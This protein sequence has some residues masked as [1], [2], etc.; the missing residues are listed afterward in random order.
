MQFLEKFRE[1]ALRNRLLECDAVIVG[2]SGGPD[3]MCLLHLLLALQDDFEK[4]RQSDSEASFPQ[5]IAA[6]LHHGFRGDAAD[7]DETLV[8]EYCEAVGAPFHAKRINVKVAAKNDGMGIEEAGREARYAFF[9]K[10]LSLYSG[11]YTSVR[12]A[13]AHHR[14]DRAET[15]LMNLFRGTGMDGLC[16]MGPR[17]NDIIRPLLFASR[18]Q[19]M[20]YVKENEIP[21]SED[22]TNFE[23]DFARNKWRNRILP[24]IREVSV[25]DPVDALLSTNELL[26]QDKLFFDGL[27]SDLFKIHRTPVTQSNIGLPCSCLRDNMPA[28]STRLVRHLF[29]ERFSHTADLSF[30]QISRILLLAESGSGNKRI[31]LS[32]GKIARI[33]S[34]TLFFSETAESG[35]DTLHEETYFGTDYMV[36]GRA[37]EEEIA[38]FNEIAAKPEAAGKIIQAS[39]LFKLEVILVENPEQVVYNSRT[40]YCPGDALANV[41]VRT[42]R[43]QDHITPAGRTSG[44]ELRRFLTDRK[45]PSFIRGRMILLADESGICWIPGV[46]HAKGFVDEVSCKRFLESSSCEG[47]FLQGCRPIYRVTIL[48]A[49]I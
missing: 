37:W 48:D 34:D 31:S 30:R 5:I 26:C 14:E 20:E 2:V 36:L 49:D 3:S 7:H 12:I 46:A 35:P 40:W 10:L 1:Y 9:R 15:M 29:C 44:K 6:H 27:V 16:A 33:E 11:D 17:R 25:K 21:F 43:P 8:R 32:G 23:N 19:I 39:S 45:V 24:L 13:I 42:A 18:E 4:H 47:L 38:V 41:T 28:I 22:A